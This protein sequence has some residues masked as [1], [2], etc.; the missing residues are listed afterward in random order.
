MT[1]ISL[2]KPIAD[3]FAADRGDAEAVAVCFTE[4]AVVKDEGNT[5]K[6]RLEIARWK[7]EVSAKYEYTNEPIRIEE[8]NG[9]VIVTSHLAGNFPGSPVDLRYF[10]KLEGGKIAALETAL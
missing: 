5:Y 3:Y 1:M 9:T 2:P 8:V 4:N 6:G 7:A 10:F